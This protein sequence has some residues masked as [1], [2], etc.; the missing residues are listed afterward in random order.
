MAILLKQRI[1]RK[2]RASLPVD[3]HAFE[4]IGDIMRRL[5]REAERRITAEFSLP[6]SLE[7]DYLVDAEQRLGEGSS[8]VTGG[9]SSWQRGS[10]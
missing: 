8:F 10:R 9:A 6:L 3:P 5:R 1:Q 4:S 7:I 2:R